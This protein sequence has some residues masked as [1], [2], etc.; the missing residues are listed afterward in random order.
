MA[1]WIDGKS[2]AASVKQA[3]THTVRQ[4]AAQGTIPGLAVVLV[5]DDPASHVYVRN[6]TRACDEV[7]IAHWQHTLPAITPE[8]DLLALIA[9]LNR[10]PAVHA[11]LVQLPLPPHIATPKVLAAIDPAKDADG[12]HP[13]NVGKLVLGL[14]APRPCTP[15][16]VMEILR[17][18][19]IATR[20]QQAVVIGRSHIVGKPMALMLLGADATVTICHKWSTDIATSIRNADLVVSAVGQPGII[21]GDWIK[22]GAAVIDVGITRTANGTLAGDVD[23]AAAERAAWLTPVPGGV[24]PMTIAMLLRTTVELSKPS[25]YVP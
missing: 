5:G 23:P 15:L 16:G 9:T 3:V 2:L 21:R 4:M 20:G 14:P 1:Q 25:Q 24:G 13:L 17:A 7:G 6:K 10:D 18:H 12:F 11:I 19:Q 22:P 8:S